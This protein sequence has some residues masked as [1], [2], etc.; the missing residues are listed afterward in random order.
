[1]LQIRKIPFNNFYRTASKIVGLKILQRAECL[2][3]KTVLLLLLAIV[4]KT[5]SEF[6]NKVQKCIR[7]GISPRKQHTNIFNMIHALEF[8]RQTMHSK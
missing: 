1:M 5:K 4:K 8:L 2:F 3:M 7:W 6:Q